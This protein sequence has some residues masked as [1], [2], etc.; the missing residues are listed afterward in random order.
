MQGS[1]NLKRNE[2][3]RESSIDF[4]KNDKSFTG[5]ITNDDSSAAQHADGSGTC[6]E[7]LRSYSYVG[8]SSI[9]TAPYRHY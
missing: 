9:C 7:L 4:H 2:V 6:G 1:C 3:L 8:R 5:V